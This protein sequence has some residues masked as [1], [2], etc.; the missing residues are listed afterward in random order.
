[1]PATAAA[2]ELGADDRDHLDAG[3]AQQCVGERVAVVGEDDAGLEG[4]GVV[5]AVPLLPL[6]LVDVAA[7]VDDLDR[8]QAERAATTSTNGSAALVATSTPGAVS[9]GCSVNVCTA[10][11][12]V[13]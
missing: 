4:D 2:A 11:M 6:G 5:A 9:A 1:M 13:G 8:R 7:G 3:L 12:I 10:S